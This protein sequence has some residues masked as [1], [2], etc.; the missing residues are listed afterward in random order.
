MFWRKKKD[1]IEDN[2]QATLCVSGTIIDSFSDL[3]IEKFT[4]FGVKKFELSKNPSVMFNP[5]IWFFVGESKIELQN[6][7]G[8]GLGP[9]YASINYVDFGLGCLHARKERV[10]LGT[11][12]SKMVKRKIIDF[13]GSQTKVQIEYGEDLI[14]AIKISLENPVSSNNWTTQAPILEQHDYSL[15]GRNTA[16]LN[17]MFSEIMNSVDIKHTT[18]SS[19]AFLRE[20]IENFSDYVE[21]YK[22]FFDI[23]CRSEAQLLL[24]KLNDYVAYLEQKASIIENPTIT[25][26]KNPIDAM[27]GSEFEQWCADL[28]SRNGFKKVQV[29]KGSGDQGVDILACK[30]DIKYAIQCKC[31]KEKLGNTPVQEV[32]AGKSMYNCHVGVVMTNS[33]FTDGAKQLADATGVL[34]WDRN[35]ILSM[36][37][38]EE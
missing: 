37:N 7:S 17:T 16:K 18:Y 28:L 5:V 21:K 11:E 34:L 4:H 38:D 31:Y 8:I 25:Q 15:S 20:R 3:I 33:F 1:R 24:M 27:S 32:H 9:V 19:I 29:T 36:L 13:Y 2:D 35:K 30:N 6:G 10:L 12:I 26:F 22:A 23:K 14:F